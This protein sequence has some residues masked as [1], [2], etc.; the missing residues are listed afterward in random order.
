VS[1]AHPACSVVVTTFERPR[2]LELCLAAFARQSVRD[3]ELLVADDGSGPDTAAVV[4]RFSERAAFPVEHVWHEREGHRRTVILNRAIAAARSDYVVFT[5]GDCLPAADFL[6]VHL[7][8]RQRGRLLFG[9]STALE[10]STSE[11]ADGAWVASGAF[12]RLAGRRERLRLLAQHLRNL[13]WIA[14]RRRRRPHNKARNMSAYR[15]DLLR[16]NGFD[17][18]FLGWGSADGDLRERLKMVEVWPKSVFHRAFVF[19][20]WHEKG[21]ERAANA[22]YARRAEVPAFAKLGIV[23]AKQAE[24]RETGT[25]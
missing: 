25:R 1:G 19:H 10:R 22:A 23:K 2:Y 6:E 4:R 14:R 8:G 16:V 3:L 20:L 12:E 9:G 13:W 24:Q 15:E 18:A 5:D 7:R 11:R 21:P 17:E